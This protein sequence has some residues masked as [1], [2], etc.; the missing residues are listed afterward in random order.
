MG[1][2]YIAYIV[3]IYCICLC[4]AR[5]LPQL[6][7]V[8]TTGSIY[9]AYIVYIYIVYAYVVQDIYRNSILYDGLD[10]YCIY[11]I[12]ILYMLMLCKIFTATPYCTTGSI[13][14]AYIV[15]IY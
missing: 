3:Y 4:C 9:I 1:S 2:I 10:I 5:Y 12:Y 7:I 8:Q 14:I 11:C 13:Y 15:Y 6:H